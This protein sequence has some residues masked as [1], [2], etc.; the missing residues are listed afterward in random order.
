MIESLLERPEFVDY[1]TY[2]WSDVLMLNGT[3]LRPDALKAYDA[4]LEQLAPSVA[5]GHGHSA[6]DGA[7]ARMAQ[8]G[9]VQHYRLS[10]QEYAYTVYDLLA[11]VFDPFLFL[12][13]FL[14]S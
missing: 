10:R 2:K 13:S 14:F 12:C 4:L 7:A 8:R 6:R 3:L 9:R 1:W 11:V 5:V